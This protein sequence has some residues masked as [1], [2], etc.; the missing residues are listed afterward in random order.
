MSYALWEILKG[1]E[2]RTETCPQPALAHSSCFHQ[3][4]GKEQGPQPQCGEGQQGEMLPAL[5]VCLSCS[6]PVQGTNTPTPAAL[7]S[8]KQCLLF[9]KRDTALARG[10]NTL[11]PHLVTTQHFWNAGVQHGNKYVQQVEGCAYRKLFG[12]NISFGGFTEESGWAATFL[13]G[14]NIPMKGKGAPRLCKMRLF[15]KVWLEGSQHLWN[16]L[17]PAATNHMYKNQTKTKTNH[18]KTPKKT[19]I[20]ILSL[21]F[22][23]IT[24]LSSFPLKVHCAAR[25]GLDLTHDFLAS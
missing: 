22:S 4:L 19:S 25:T 13:I 15:Q 3:L 8:T 5:R 24:F 21:F 1:T 16:M 17:H 20:E 11:C 10:S 14:E 12:A 2:S 7:L 6:L 18:Q 23:Y 9:C